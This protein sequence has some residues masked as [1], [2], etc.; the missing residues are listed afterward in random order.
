MKEE[1]RN[2]VVEGKENCWY[3][4][5]NH[6]VL[7]SHLTRGGRRR[8][9]SP[10]GELNYD[11]YKFWFMKPAPTGKK[12]R[13]SRRLA[14][15]LNFPMGFLD[16]DWDYMQSAKS[17]HCIRKQVYVHQLVMW[18]F[19]PIDKYPPERL[20]NCWSDIPT[21]AQQWIK[22]T[23]IINHIDHNSYNNRLDNLEWVTPRENT[24]A[25]I[26]FYGKHYKSKKA[27]PIK[28]MP[29]LEFLFK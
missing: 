7:K 14:I 22:D 3:E 16:D 5:S 23:A 6:G 17:S 13:S 25:A 18:T 8:D 9:G 21:D 24:R 26:K 29:T 20:K 4:I 10:G 19:R 1:W 28:K 27:K 12:T 11:P 2:I 15:V